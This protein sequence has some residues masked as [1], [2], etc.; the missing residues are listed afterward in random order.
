MALGLDEDVPNRQ[1]AGIVAFQLHSGPPMKLRI[2]DIE[3]PRDRQP[4]DREMN[5][6]CARILLVGLALAPALAVAQDDSVLPGFRRVVIDADPA[7]ATV[8][9]NGR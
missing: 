8:L 5:R 9:Q 3:I 2:K 1:A 6:E 7:Q 4:G